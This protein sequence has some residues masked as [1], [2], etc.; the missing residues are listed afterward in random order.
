MGVDWSW[1]KNGE[2]CK[3]SNWPENGEGVQ[4]LMVTWKRR[5]CAKTQTDLKTQ[6]VCKDSN[7]PENGEGVQRLKVT[8]KPRRSAKTQADLK[9]EKVCKYFHCQGL[10]GGSAN[11]CIFI[12]DGEEGGDSSVVRAP[13][14]W[15][16][17]RGFESLQERRESFL[18]QGQ[19]FVL[20]YFGIRS[21]PVLLQ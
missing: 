12:L 19:L 15:L 3:D 1:P 4:W 10:H 13:D 6:R 7:W 9:T 11:T 18:L 8:W 14:S 5:G 17:G 2:V 20:T 16:K 21:T